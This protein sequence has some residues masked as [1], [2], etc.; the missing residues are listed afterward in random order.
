MMKKY[1]SLL[2]AL[3]L[4]L[5]LCACGGNKEEP[6]AE[7]P[8]PVEEAPAEA[9]SL[10]EAELPVVAIESEA[11]PVSVVINV[12]VSDAGVLRVANE[13]VTVEDPDGDGTVT[14]DQVLAAAHDAFYEGG[15]AA[16]CAFEQTE[17]GTSITKLWGVDNGGSYGYYVNDAF[18]LPDYK[19]VAG[20]YICAYSY[21]DLIAWSDCYAFFDRRNAELAA[22]EE[23][24]LQLSKLAYDENWELQT[25]LTEGATLVVNGEITDS[26][27]DAEGNVALKLDEAGTYTVTAIGAEGETLV[28]PV[29]IVTVK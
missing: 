13:P 23:L 22:G 4:C 2:L 17:Y 10:E 3:V 9:A 18:V 15:A 14:A 5:S 8:A 19:L 25:V 27:T 16:G 11:E 29:C 20:D 21:A 28:P 6:K 24:K 12:S 7:E 26:V 1:A